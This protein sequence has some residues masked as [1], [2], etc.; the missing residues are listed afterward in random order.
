MVVLYSLEFD[1]V[2]FLIKEPHKSIITS[3]YNCLNRKIRDLKMKDTIA[4]FQSIIFIW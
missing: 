3:L 1:T 4:F 2:D